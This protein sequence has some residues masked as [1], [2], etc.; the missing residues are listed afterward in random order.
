MKKLVRPVLHVK[1]G[2]KHGIIRA[3]CFR[4]RCGAPLSRC[5][6][7]NERGAWFMK[8][9]FAIM[10]KIAEVPDAIPKST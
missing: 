10:L 2:A 1:D 9:R 3:F 7:E 5:M 8:K 6:P 4:A